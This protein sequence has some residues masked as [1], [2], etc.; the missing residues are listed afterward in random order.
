V[1]AS[2]GIRAR[3]LLMC[4]LCFKYKFWELVT[5]YGFSYEFWRAILMNLNFSR[6]GIFIEMTI[7][8]IISFIIYF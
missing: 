3:V 4:I 6:V 7:N 5:F 1:R 2:S 8:I